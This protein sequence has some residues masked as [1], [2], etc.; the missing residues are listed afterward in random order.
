M[1]DDAANLE[2]VL[3]PEEAE[4]ENAD[5]E[6]SNEAGNE[7]GICHT[8]LITKCESLVVVHPTFTLFWQCKKRLFVM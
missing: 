4:E 8:E 5:A 2:A 6:E 7:E 3:E 1:E